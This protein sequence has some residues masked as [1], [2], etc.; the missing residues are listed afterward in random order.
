[1]GPA[2]EILTITDDDSAPTVTLE[3]SQDLH[4]RESRIHHRPGEAEP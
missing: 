4:Q 2:D 3:L 1:M